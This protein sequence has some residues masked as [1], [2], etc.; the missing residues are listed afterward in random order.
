M[1]KEDNEKFNYSLRSS[2]QMLREKF[3]DLVRDR[4]VTDHKG[5]YWQIYK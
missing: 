3:V 1:L 2:K 4:N 5:C